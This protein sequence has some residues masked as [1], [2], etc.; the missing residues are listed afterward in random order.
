MVMAT[1]LEVHSISPSDSLGLEA[2]SRINAEE[3]EKGMFV[4]FEGYK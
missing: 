1:S 3:G 4:K 2:S